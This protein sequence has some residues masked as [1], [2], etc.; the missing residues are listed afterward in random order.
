MI[1]MPGGEAPIFS[2]SSSI[3]ARA[4]RF[5]IR[6]LNPLAKPIYLPLESAMLRMEKNSALVAG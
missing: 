4:F 2:I 1:S 3:L 6:T 5:R